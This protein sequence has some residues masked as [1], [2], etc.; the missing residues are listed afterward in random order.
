MLTLLVRAALRL[1]FH[2]ILVLIGVVS[3]NRSR[4]NQSGTLRLAAQRYVPRRAQGA[5]L[6]NGRI[7]EYCERT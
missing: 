1:R 6:A 5:R 7:D 3:S 4:E 2:V